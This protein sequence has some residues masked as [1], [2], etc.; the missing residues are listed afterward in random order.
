MTPTPSQTPLPPTPL[1]KI[2][3]TPAPTATPFS[4]T[5]V[6]GD[7]L[8]A[9]AYFYGVTIEELLAANPGIDPGFLS[10][11]ATLV[12]PLEGENPVSQ[13]T[14]TPIPVFAEPSHCYGSADGS[15]W[16]F[17]LVANTES[18][19]LENLTAWIGL[20]D[21]EGT[22][23]A[24][25]TAIAPLDLLASGQSMPLVAYFPGPLPSGF[26]PLGEVTAALPVAGQDERYLA[27]SARVDSVEI[28]QAGK[29]AVVRGTVVLPADSQTAGKVWVAV[30]AYDAAGQVVGVRK[31]EAES[32]EPCQESAQGSE[33]ECLTFEINVFSL[34]PAIERVEALVEARP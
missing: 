20:F 22:N 26:T 15:A 12:I 1:P 10:I 11:D 23:F 4:H 33:V 24:N 9:I 6:K 31:W 16:C 21:S 13:P 7:T 18:H 25:G 32:Q 8:G 19:A 14:Q 27:A 28:A 5:I 2:P 30:L 3:I 29:Q 17:L 34:G